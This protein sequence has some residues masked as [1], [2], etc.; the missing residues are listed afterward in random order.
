MTWGE[1][2]DF[3]YYINNPVQH[4]VGRVTLC[5]YSTQ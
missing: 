4:G 3:V 5:S 1:Q 2:R